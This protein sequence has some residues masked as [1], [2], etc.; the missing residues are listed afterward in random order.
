MSLTMSRKMHP[1]IHTVGMRIF[2]GQSTIPI[3]I[4][5]HCEKG[6]K[7][8]FGLTAKQRKKRFS[9]KRKKENP[10]FMRINGFQASS[11][12]RNAKTSMSSQEFACQVCPL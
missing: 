5:L 1:W 2:D 8:D 12:C 9:K 7:K 11:C 3:D 4:S 6:K 10:N